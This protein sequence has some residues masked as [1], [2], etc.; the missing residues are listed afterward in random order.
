MAADL[1]K[2]EYAW[3]LDVIKKFKNYASEACQL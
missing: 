2:Q 3:R 1:G